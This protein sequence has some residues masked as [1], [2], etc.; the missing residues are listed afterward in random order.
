[1]PVIFGIFVWQRCAEAPALNAV[2][3][4]RAAILIVGPISAL[5]VLRLALTLPLLLIFP[6]LPLSRLAL[7]RLSGLTLARLTLS[8]LSRL[9]L[10]RLPLARLALPG[11]AALFT[12]IA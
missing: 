11:L 1:M 10:A 9:S 12:W 8:G 2:S 4:P 6:L 7:P 3:I 5:L